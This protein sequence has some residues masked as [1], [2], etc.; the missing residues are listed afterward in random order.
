VIPTRRMRRA[1]PVDR[2]F[3]AV[4][5]PPWGGR[6]G[7]ADAADSKSVARV[8]ELVDA[9]ASKAVFRKEVGVRFPSLAPPDLRS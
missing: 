6:G 5:V 7:M 9:T 3:D 2:V 4:I 1:T 8:A